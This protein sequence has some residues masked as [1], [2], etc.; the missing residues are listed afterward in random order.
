MRVSS[1]LISRIKYIGRRRGELGRSPEVVLRQW[2][3]ILVVGLVSFTTA[4][5]YAYYRFYYWSDVEHRFSET[6]AK[7]VLYDVL[8]VQAVLRSYE[9][10]AAKADA[11][12]KGAALVTPDIETDQPA[13]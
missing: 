7:T 11:V 5:G 4:V 9:E 3:F 2:A 8:A 1:D 12:L 10:R 13:D 6:D